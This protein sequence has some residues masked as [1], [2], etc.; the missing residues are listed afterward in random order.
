MDKEITE[1][2]TTGEIVIFDASLF[3]QDAMQEK[4]GQDDLALPFL[5]DLS[6]QDPTLDDLPDA[7]AGDIYNTVTQEVYD[8]KE[9]IR[10]VPCAYERRFLEW[11]PRGQGT[12]AP[13]NIYTPDQERPETSRDPDTNRDQVVGG[14]SY[15]EETHQHYV[16]IV[17]GDKAFSTA[18]LAM[19]STQLKKSRKWNSMIQS[20]TMMGDK[21]PFTPP[22][23]SHIYH[24]KTIA[25]ENSKGSWHG[26]DI[27]LDSQVKDMYL[28]Q[29]ARA[30]NE[31]VTAGDVEVRHTTEAG[32][33]DGVDAPF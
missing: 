22:R 21:G 10:V 13:I 26:W 25:E 6:R 16:L 29:A 9:G 2:E 1:T 5:K 24:L 23:Y 32:D 30:F 15:I 20:R 14:D 27:S 18:L 12:G 11:V 8:G 19:K 28:Y 31:T 33:G 17:E 4:L 7:K 3:E